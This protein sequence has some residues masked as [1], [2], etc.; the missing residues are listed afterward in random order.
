MTSIVGVHLGNFHSKHSA[1]VALRVHHGKISLAS[2]HDEIG[3]RKRL[4]GD[5][6]IV[7]ILAHIGELA[8]VVLDVALTQPPCVSCRLAVCPGI[9]SCPS[10]EVAIMQSLVLA[11]RAKTSKKPINPQTHRVWDLYYSHVLGGKVVEPCFSSTQVALTIRGMTLQKRLHGQNFKLAETSVLAVLER[12]HAQ[13][14][15]MDL[16]A[17]RDFRNGSLE[18]G[19]ILDRLLSLQPSSCEIALTTDER[20]VLAKSLGLFC[21]FLAAYVGCADWLGLVPEP[22]GLMKGTDSWVILPDP[23]LAENK[24]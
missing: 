16:H 15:T 13:L 10:E 23:F 24:L 21:A 5:E 19:R 11:N 4:D 6:R 3:V 9:E 20:V 1:L 7:A 12:W 2:L 8:E 18:R 14:G 22:S 17:Y